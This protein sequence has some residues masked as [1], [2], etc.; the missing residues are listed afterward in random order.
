MYFLI[1]KYPTLKGFIRSCFEH[2]EMD[3]LFDLLDGIQTEDFPV[4]N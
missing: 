1:I 2:G 4:Y 3:K